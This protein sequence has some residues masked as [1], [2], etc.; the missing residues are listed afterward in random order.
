MRNTTRILTA[1]ALLT[2]TAC[3][4]INVMDASKPSSGQVAR[5]F[6]FRKTL[7]ARVDYL[8]FLPK[9]YDAKAGQHWPLILFLHGAGERGTNVWKV[10][11]HG[12]AKY[13]VTQADFPFIIVSPLCPQGKIWSKEV[14]L[15][16]LDEVIAKYAVDT[17]RVYLTGLSM[18]GYGTWDLG[19]THPEKFAALVPICGGGQMIGVILSSRDNARALK[20][21]GVWAFHGGKDTVVPLEESQRMVAALKK[22][23]VADVKLT[24]YPEATHDSWTETYKNPDLYRWLLQHDRRK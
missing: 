4:A 23:G 11:T 19:L 5:Q 12:P 7:S 1:A 21:L 14:L 20:T 17:N 22:E 6:E 8:L 3:T 16:L 15:A 10:A 13:A 18:G 24:V 2:L 9:G